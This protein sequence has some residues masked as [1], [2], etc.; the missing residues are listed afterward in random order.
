MTEQ[1]IAL[2]VGRTRVSNPWAGS[3][4]KYLQ[5]IYQIDDVPF[6][7]VALFTHILIYTLIQT[8]ISHSFSRANRA[9]KPLV[10]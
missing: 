10:K 8:V 9:A 4:A 3:H 1:K 7:Q 2:F 5:I 6:T